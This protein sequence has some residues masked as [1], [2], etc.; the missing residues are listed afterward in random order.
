MPLTKRACIISLFLFTFQSALQ[1]QVLPEQIK[2]TRQASKRLV[3]D[4]D[5]TIPLAGIWPEKSIGFSIM[6]PVIHQ[7]KDSAKVEIVSS[8]LAIRSLS[9]TATNIWFGGFN[10]VATYSLDLAS[11]KGKGALGFTFFGKGSK[12]KFTIKVLF[13][14]EKPVGVSLH[15]TDKKGLSKEAPIEVN[16]PQNARLNGKLYLQML[17]SGL[18]LYLKDGD[19]PQ[20]IAQSDFNHLIDLRKKEY[21]HSFQSHLFVALD[22]GEIKLDKVLMGLS[23]G[24]GLADIRAITYED[25]S[26]LLDKGRLW[27]TMSIRG[28]ALPHHIQGVFSM[29]PSVF[30]IKLEGVIL[31]DRG[32]GLLRN[33]VA[34]HL[35]FDRNDN[36]WKGLTTGF[37][38][39]ANPELE[40]KQLLAIQ[41][42]RDPR[43]GFSI[44]E[45][46]AFGVVGDIE[47]PHILY[48][49]EAKKWRMLTCVN[50][51]G[52]KAIVMEADEWDKGYVKIAG[53]VSHN[54]TGTSIQ[55]IGNEPY[56]FSG[57]S[58][59]E[60]FIYTY[61]DL[62]EAGTLKMDLPPWDKSSGTR[63]WPN[64]VQLP[65]G[66]PFRYVAL[67]MD[68]INY[69]GM[70]GPNWTYGALYLYHGF[71]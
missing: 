44:M 63:V 39:Y 57:S 51:G 64:V 59:R 19:L 67:M 53:P 11:C 16:F 43:F 4:E 40:K 28:R 5:Q 50:E 15:Y 22:S 33:E 42:R 29:N 38:A 17:G 25:G 62:K 14:D 68:R 13:N 70:V 35:V 10:P 45:A 65:E 46:K 31:F 6:H 55:K 48:D 12:E 26:P 30:D 71:E 56:C 32:D 7:L 58:E 49:E 27:Y 41:S 9:K 37:S 20:V 18:V 1:S 23:T 3:F 47:D 66:Y 34:S 8:Q 61:P 54:S 24:V 2:F 60:I 36:L 21:L 52:Y 69:P